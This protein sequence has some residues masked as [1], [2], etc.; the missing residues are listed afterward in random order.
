MA[1]LP[2]KS[3]AAMP[4]QDR[5]IGRIALNTVLAVSLAATTL[6]P[7]HCLAGS[8]LLVSCGAHLAVH[9]RWIRTVILDRPKNFTAGVRRQRRL[10]WAAVLSG[11]LCGLS[12]VAVESA[13]L[14]LRHCGI[15]VHAV[16]GLVFWGLN[17]YH[18][19]LHRNW[20]RRKLAAIRTA[21]R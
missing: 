4:G 3:V 21:P 9:E 7:L 17:V 11:V 1:T 2:G 12:G 14:T 10:F 18:L 15:A 19:V 20:F 16:S 13:A 5:Q 6:P 8:V